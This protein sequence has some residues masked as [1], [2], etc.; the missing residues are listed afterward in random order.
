M[1]AL[2]RASMEAVGVV[3]AVQIQAQRKRIGQLLPLFR[4][5]NPPR[6]TQETA[7]ITPPQ[8]VGLPTR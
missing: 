2:G 5:L 4:L 7:T 6:V 1:L 3:R 8:E